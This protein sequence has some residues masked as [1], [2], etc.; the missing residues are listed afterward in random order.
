MTGAYS[1]CAQD[2]HCQSTNA[3]TTTAAPSAG[4]PTS[5]RGLAAQSRSNAAR[6]SAAGGL[7]GLGEP[8]HPNTK[9]NTTTAIV[10]TPAI[11][12][13]L[14]RNRGTA[15]GRGVHAAGST[16]HAANRTPTP[17]ISPAGD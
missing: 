3:V 12:R 14:H 5:T 10:S 16:V 17:R 9:D 8:G 7:A 15:G 2:G 4:V 13:Y 1:R 11:V 6:S